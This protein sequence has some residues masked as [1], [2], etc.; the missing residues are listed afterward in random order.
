M[1]RNPTVTRLRS[2]YCGVNAVRTAGYSP[3]SSAVVPNTNGGYSSRR[4]AA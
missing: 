3:A 1:R 4:N 2:S